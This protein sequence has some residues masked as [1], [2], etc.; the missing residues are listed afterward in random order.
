MILKEL[1]E[2]IGISGREEAVRRVILQAI[3]GHAQDITIDPLGS[4]TA[5]KPRQ[6]PARRVCCWRLIWMKSASW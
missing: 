5:R 4:V 1:S 3:E 6:R 2:A